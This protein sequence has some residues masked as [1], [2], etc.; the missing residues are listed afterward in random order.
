MGRPPLEIGTWGAVHTRRVTS[1]GVTP[2]KWSASTRFRDADGAT[3]KVERWGATENK[4]KARLNKAL[5][6][7]AGITGEVLTPAS[8][9]CQAANLWLTDLDVAGTTRD[10][11]RSR[12]NNHVL[13]ALGQ[14]LLRECTVGRLEHYFQQL[15]DAGVAPNTRRGIRTVISEVLQLAVRHDVLE[16]NPVRSMKRIRGKARRPAHAMENHEL[17]DFLQKVDDD[18]LAR[19]ADLP[20]LIRFL[21]GTGVRYGE[22][23][24]V[25]WREVNLTDEPITIE[26]LKIPPRHV[27]VSGNIVY[28]EGVGLVRHEG[29][30]F[31][32]LRVIPLPDYLWTVLLVRRPINPDPYEP[33]FPSAMLGWRHPC[34]VQR[35]VRRLRA[36]IGYP[37]FTTHVGRKTVATALDDEGQTARKIADLLGHANPSM[38]QDV[39]MGRGRANPAAAKVLDALVRPKGA[40]A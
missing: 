6:E 26:G 24:A 5:K 15:K 33:I 21:F 30:T 37:H 39:Y 28:V 23:L 16:H 29:K 11:Y 2:E 36:R 25:R 8:R 35:S 38:T 14:L 27:L 22:A 13:P 18:R 31:A 34:N 20:D 12:L 17:V 4:A 3:R 9:F 10:R 40:A 1:E 7:R 32:A 19:R